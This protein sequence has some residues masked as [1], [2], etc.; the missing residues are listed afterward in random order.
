MK[1]SGRKGQFV[2]SGPSEKWWRGF[3][4]RHQAAI[5][6]STP[7]N[8]HRGRGRMANQTVI[9][10]HFESL[11]KLM[12]KIGVLDKPALFNVD[13]SGLNMECRTGKVSSSAA[14]GG[15]PKAPL[16]FCYYLKVGEGATPFPG[17]LR[18]L[19]PACWYSFIDLERMKG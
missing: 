10:R 7:D 14:A 9:D 3:K 17:Q 2:D 5:T 6:L 4:K 13:E 11:K 15:D 1:K 16:S 19:T 12:I 8:L 18:P